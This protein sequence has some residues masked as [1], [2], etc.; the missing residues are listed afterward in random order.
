MTQYTASSTQLRSCPTFHL[1]SALRK[2]LHHYF[3]WVRELR[4]RHHLIAIRC[5]LF[6]CQSYVLSASEE[7]ADSLF[8][9]AR[10]NEHW[11]GKDSETQVTPDACNQS[12]NPPSSSS[13][14]S[15]STSPPPLLLPMFLCDGFKL[16]VPFVQ[17]MSTPTENTL[18]FSF[19]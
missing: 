16:R 2:S 9:Y 19:L 18:F 15:S 5:V 14:F 13:S 11:P 3:L 17:G 4:Q 12:L 6:S 1:C 8:L 10:S 7:C